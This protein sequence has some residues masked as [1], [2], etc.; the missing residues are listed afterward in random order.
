MTT[1][2]SSEELWVYLTTSRMLNKP[3]S[4]VLDTRE[5][6]L[7]EVSRETSLTSHELRTTYHERRIHANTLLVVRVWWWAL[8]G[9][10]SAGLTANFWSCFCVCFRE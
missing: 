10:R 1:Q 3:A 8:W 9:G 6:C 4:G 2:C 5:A 7:V